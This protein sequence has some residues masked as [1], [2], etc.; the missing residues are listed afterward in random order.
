MDLLLLIVILL[1]GLLIKYLID[2]INS[3]NKEL[4]EI[5]EKC[6]SSNGESF[7]INTKNPTEL[8]NANLIQNLKYF[9]DYFENRKDI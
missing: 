8:F 5:K 6:I 4:K 2:T 7:S 9:R 3:L 1:A